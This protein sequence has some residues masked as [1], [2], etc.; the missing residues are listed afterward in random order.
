[1]KLKKIFQSGVLLGCFASVAASADVLYQPAHP[2]FFAGFDAGIMKESSEGTVLLIMQ[3][4]VP[5][6]VVLCSM[7]R[8]DLSL[9]PVDLLAIF[10]KIK[11]IYLSHF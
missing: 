4:S 6:P 10:L 9:L 11:M 8:Q 1:M 2:G 5:V 3:V 7:Q